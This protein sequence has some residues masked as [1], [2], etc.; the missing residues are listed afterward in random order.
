MQ[1][2]YS[3]VFKNRNF[4][5]YFRVRGK[6][7]HSDPRHFLLEVPPGPLTL[8]LQQDLNSGGSVAEEIMAMKNLLT[9]AVSELQKLDTMENNIIDLKSSVEDIKKSNVEMKTELSTVKKE[10]EI[11]KEKNKTLED[12]IIDIQSRS[13]RDN[14]IFYNIK[15]EK[16]VGRDIAEE[17]KVTTEDILNEFI[18]TKLKIETVF[19]LERVHRMGK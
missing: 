19:S 14:L 12:S 18:K 5:L 15:E 13:V 2:I 6:A 3:R 8:P 4:F 9:K 16:K 10:L 1:K 7:Q 11:M 17:E